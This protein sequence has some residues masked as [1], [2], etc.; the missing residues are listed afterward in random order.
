VP[1]YRRARIT[2]GTYF[3]TVVTSQ[4]LPLL[5]SASAVSALHDSFA[6]VAACHPFTIDAFV[7]LP[8]HLHC[9]WT[10]PQGDEDFSTRW[11]LVKTGFSRV[12]QKWRRRRIPPIPVENTDGH[13]WQDRFWEH[14]IRD[15]EDF[16]AHCDYIHYNP[17]KHGLVE[18]PGDWRY[19]TFEALV[20]K[21]FYPTDWGRSV[22]PQVMAM[23]LE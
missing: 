13:L 16:N 3:F 7:V 8:D 17:V 19:S 6:A 21:G 9:M 12:Y 18:S 11:R 23:D 2:G 22:S 10:L 4:R 20:Q 15:Q 1:N 14:L 5:A